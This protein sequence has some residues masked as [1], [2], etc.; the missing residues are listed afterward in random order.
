MD[1]D[2]DEIIDRRGTHSSKWDEMGDFC[3]LT[4]PDA[5][6][7]W[8]A[9][10]DFRPPSTVQQA[11][12]TM[13]A[14]G[15]Y[16]YYGD[17]HACREAISWWMKTRHG[18]DVPEAGLFFT[19]GLVNGAAVCIDAFT[20][21]GDRIVLH[22]PVYHAFARVIRAA[23]RTVV[24]CPMTQTD[25]RYGFDFAAMEAAMTGAERMFILCSPHNPG[26][27]VWSPDDLR[28]VADLCRRHGLLLLSDEIHHDLVYPGAKHTVTALAA[29]DFAD[30]IITMTAPSKTFNIAGGHTGN[31]I[32]ADEGLRKR[33]AG[34]MMALGL[35]PNAFGMR[36]VEAA[37]S[38][39]G[40]A[41]ADALIRYLDGNRRL[42]DEAIAKIPG[43]RS[44]PLEATYL[45]WVDFSGAGMDAAE[46]ARRVTG[47][48]HIAVNAG[49]TFGTGGESFLRFNFATPRARVKEAVSRLHDAFA[50]LQ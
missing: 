44:M 23:G 16:G 10:M 28:A 31:V 46:A 12:E 37:Y 48:A 6:P 35:S 22:T 49:P 50:D 40:A 33:F 32:I 18:W 30:R 3:G 41:W 25:G 24:E 20:E 27:R 2:F 43:L 8:V 29:P 7:M 21:P 34:R 47:Q 13:A 42:F 36:M 45:A 14:T 1:F 4:A 9:D 19:H 26:G 15:V 38:P 11:I 39:T 5:L 17:D